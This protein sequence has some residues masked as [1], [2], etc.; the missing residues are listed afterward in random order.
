MVLRRAAACIEFKSF[1][2]RCQCGR[3]R[4]PFRL[5]IPMIH[6]LLETIKHEPGDLC[7]DWPRHGGWQAVSH[8]RQV[9]R[10]RP[11][12]RCARQHCYPAPRSCPQPPAKPQPPPPFLFSRSPSLPF[13]ASHSQPSRKSCSS[14]SLMTTCCEYRARIRGVGPTE[15]VSQSLPCFVACLL[16]SSVRCP[17]LPP[18]LPLSSQLSLPITHTV[19]VVCRVLAVQK[20]HFQGTCGTIHTR[21]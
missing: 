20:W 5:R 11:H 3:A 1:P 15:R 14:A 2:S 7:G 16:P 18:H 19:S 6:E 10:R 13:S 12:V 17:P 4:S 21:A 8:G 9:F